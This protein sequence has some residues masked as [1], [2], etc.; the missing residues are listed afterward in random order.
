M[1]DTAFQVAAT[2]WDEARATYGARPAANMDRLAIAARAVADWARTQSEE[3]SPPGPI[4]RQVRA[5]IAQLGPLDGAKATYAEIAYRLARAL[6]VDDGEGATGLSGAAR[7]LRAALDAVWK[8]VR[9]AVPADRSPDS[10][11]TPVG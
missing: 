4:E 2:A 11:G 1:D 10:L 5:D 8:G 7:E 9:V 3:G 6:D